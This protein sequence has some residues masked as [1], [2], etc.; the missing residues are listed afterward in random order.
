M[1]DMAPTAEQ[2]GTFR[3]EEHH[4]RLREGIDLNSITSLPLRGGR[5]GAVVGSL[6]HSPESRILHV[7]DP[8]AVARLD[9]DLFHEVS[10]P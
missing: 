10:I 8:R 4:K 2:S 7:D 5:A 9:D 1:F 3:I 6:D